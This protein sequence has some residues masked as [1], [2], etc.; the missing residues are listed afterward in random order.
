MVS[1]CKHNRYKRALENYS[2]EDQEIIRKG[3]RI[4]NKFLDGGQ[5]VVLSNSEGKKTPILNEDA[6]G[7]INYKESCKLWLEIGKSDAKAIYSDKKNM[8][9]FLGKKFGL[10]TYAQLLK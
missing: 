10:C 2:L 8:G 4:T 3:K 7:R 9:Y 5:G 6:W 1:L